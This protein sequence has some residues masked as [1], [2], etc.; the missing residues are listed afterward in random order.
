MPDDQESFG[1]HWD[2]N[3]SAFQHWEYQPFITVLSDEKGWVDYAE[4]FYRA[5]E[6]LLQGLAVGKG[7]PDVEGV[8]GMFLF[9]HYLELVLKRIIVRGRHLVDRQQNAARE[10]VKEVANIH[11]LK[12]LW[13][14]VLRDAK[15]KIEDRTWDAYDIPFLE[16]CL[17]E[18]DARDRKGFA[19]RYPRQGGER[20]EYDFAWISLATEHV[21]QILSNM[22]TYLIELHGENEDWQQIQNSFYSRRARLLPP[23]FRSTISDGPI[24]RLHGSVGCST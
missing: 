14:L 2:D 21:Q 15:P 5:A 6:I 9:R 24:L 10:D 1:P 3:Y 12:T 17:S 7:F 8:A 18:F 23:S 19:F 13:D 20:F 22:L 4:S 11:S 16:K